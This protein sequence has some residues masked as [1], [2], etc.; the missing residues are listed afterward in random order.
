MN[1]EVPKSLSYAY[2]IYLLCQNCFSST[3]FVVLFGIVCGIPSTANDYGEEFLSSILPLPLLPL[4]LCWVDSIRFLSVRVHI[5]TGMEGVVC[6]CVYVYIYIL[7][8]PR[9]RDCQMPF[10]FSEG[11]MAALTRSMRAQSQEGSRGSTKGAR[12]STPLPWARLELPASFLNPLPPP[13]A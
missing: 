4:N 13:A 3:L 8:I 1:S 2:G 12:G 7:Y 11:S 5:I 6:V 9:T 10:S